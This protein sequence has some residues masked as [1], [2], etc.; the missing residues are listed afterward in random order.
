MQA[1]DKLGKIYFCLKKN[2][3]IDNSKGKK[4]YKLIESLSR[5]RLRTKVR[6]TY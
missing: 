3:L 2:R 5:T 4:D 1:I 6:K